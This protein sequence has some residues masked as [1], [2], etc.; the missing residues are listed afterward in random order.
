MTTEQIR[1]LTCDQKLPNIYKI[2]VVLRLFCHLLFSE[3]RINFEHRLLD[4]SAAVLL[5]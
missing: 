1:I 3:S 4:K 5:N 2:D